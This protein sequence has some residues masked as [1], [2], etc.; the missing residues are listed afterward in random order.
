MG[1]QSAVICA[2]P[3]G[4]VQT[5]GAARGLRPTF[6][7][8]LLLTVAALCSGCG[9]ALRSAPEFAFKSIYVAAAEASPIST[10]L[11]RSLAAAGTVQVLPEAQLR[12]PS[13]ETLVADVVLEVLA[14]QREKTVVGINA[15]GQVRE[16]QLRSR[17]KFRLRTAAG[18]DLV[19]D[20]EIVQQ[21]DISFN[22]SLVLAKEAEE[23][24]LYRDMQTDIVQQVLR[25]LSA[26]KLNAVPLAP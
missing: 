10:E 24:L 26:V 5:L 12:L 3:V 11:K 9:F 23:G 7:V 15:S 22:E 1:Q 18:K 4:C 13:G 21:R 20:A 25:R 14:D 19:A 17:F 6:W 16:F 2:N 8:A